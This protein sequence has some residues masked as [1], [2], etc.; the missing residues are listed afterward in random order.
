M[1]DQYV[2]INTDGVDG[3]NPWSI[4]HGGCFKMHLYAFQSSEKIFQNFDLDSTL[5][6]NTFWVVNDL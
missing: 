3:L 6:M 5:H 2:C 4:D 1:Q